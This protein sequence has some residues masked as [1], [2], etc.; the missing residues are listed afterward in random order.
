MILFIILA[1]I[2][3]SVIL[4]VFLLFDYRRDK[5]NLPIVALVGY[6]NAG[7]STLMNR[8][9]RAG[10]LAENML[11]A[12]LDPTTR[13]V[14]LPKAGGITTT[15][16]GDSADIESAAVSTKGQEVLMSD[17]VGFI[18]KLPTHLI[19]AFR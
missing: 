12:T 18:S 16:N 11:F 4:S 5:L 9:S 7:K 6:T 15:A 8:L 3:I 10:V 19:A 1:V 17:T 14:R 2:V 13:K